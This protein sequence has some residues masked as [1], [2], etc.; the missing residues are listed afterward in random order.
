M[1]KIIKAFKNLSK[2]TQ[3]ELYL[4]FSEGALERTIFPY[5]GDLEEGVIYKTEEF[6]YLVPISSIFEVK[7]SVGKQLEKDESPSV[8][9]NEDEILDEE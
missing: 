4:E 8:D 9:I 3:N 7:S 1:K 2:S 6:V 5:N